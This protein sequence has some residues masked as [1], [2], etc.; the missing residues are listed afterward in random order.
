LS[1]EHFTVEG[2]LLGVWVSEK[3][4][5]FCDTKNLPVLSEAAHIER[6]IRVVSEGADL[7]AIEL[8]DGQVIHYE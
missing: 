6:V 8:D 5:F 3:S 4:S 2:T 7:S 1:D